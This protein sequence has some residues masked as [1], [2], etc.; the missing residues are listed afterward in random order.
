MPA[1]CVIDVTLMPA[2]IAGRWTLG[3][4][5]AHAAW[6]TP[7][8]RR[9]AGAR[10]AH[11]DPTHPAFVQI[12]SETPRRPLRDSPRSERSHGFVTAAFVTVAIP[13]PPAVTIPPS[14]DPPTATPYPGDPLSPAPWAPP[15]G[16]PVPL[17]RISFPRRCFFPRCRIYFFVDRRGSPPPGPSEGSTSHS[18]PR[19]P[20]ISTGR[21]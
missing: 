13:P 18:E 15:S 11:R 1:K 4:S 14:R 6:S 9:H 10:W 7:T 19:F 2:T 20:F 8:A 3:P 12:P 17:E 5:R 16:G 21:V